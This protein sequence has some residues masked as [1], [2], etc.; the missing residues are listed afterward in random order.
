MAR[1]GHFKQAAV[2]N[3]RRVSTRSTLTL[4]RNQWMASLTR[5]SIIIMPLLKPPS[6]PEKT[7]FLPA[8]IPDWF[9]LV[10]F[11]QS[12]VAFGGVYCNAYIFGSGSGGAMC[13]SHDGA[14]STCHSFTNLH[15]MFSYFGQ[16][17]KTSLESCFFKPQ[18]LVLAS[19]NSPW[20]FKAFHKL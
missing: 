14:L 6:L 5:M 8:S 9:S 12:R 11:P 10:H 13:A 7:C 20:K 1:P 19:I 2:L 3:A 16:K 17:S 15:P 4:W 18:K